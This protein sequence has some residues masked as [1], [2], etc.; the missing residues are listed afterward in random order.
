M[1]TSPLISERHGAVLALQ[2]NQLD[3][4][5]AIGAEMKV[6]LAEQARRFC[7]DATLRCMLLTGTGD[8]FCAGGDL[9]NMTTDCST[10]GTRERM[11]LTHQAFQLLVAAE[12]PVIVAVN[13]AAVGGGLSLALIGDMVIASQ[14]AYFMAGF[15]KVGVLP[16][17]GVLY[18]LPRAVGMVQA[19]D[20]LLTNRRIDADEAK[21]I[22][23]VSRVLPQAGFFEAALALATQVA[24]GP[25]VSMGLAKALMNGG[26][27][28]SFPEF[29]LKES[30]AQAVVFGTQDFQEGNAAF[31][32]KRKPRFVGR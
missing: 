9:R 14:D 1:T 17:V 22:G 23:L 2:L 5:N 16:D 11:A 19:K 26:Y 12:K 7:D 32:E 8:T 3:N 24:Q 10:V 31:R 4:R 30:M 27:K 6:A 21:A 25:S 13:G 20:I 15:P 18:N 29:L 28:D